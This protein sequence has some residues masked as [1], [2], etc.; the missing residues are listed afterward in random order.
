MVENQDGT[1]TLNITRGACSVD[2]EEHRK[3]LERVSVINLSASV[4]CVPDR[5][6]WGFCNLKEIRVHPENEHFIVE[7]GV[8]FSKDKKKIIRY[9]RHDGGDT[10]RI[11]DCVEEI[12]EGCFAE[13]PGLRRIDIGKGVKKI[14]YRG[15]SS[16]GSIFLE[17]VYIPPTVTELCGEIFDSGGADSGMYYPVSIVGGAAGSVIEEYCYERGIDFIVVSEDAVEDFYATSVDDLKERLKK[18]IENEKEF[19][20]DEHEKGYQAKFC[21]GVLE[22]FVPDDVIAT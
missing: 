18:Q 13:V 12:A 5:L 4:E 9:F 10:Y 1:L 14:G 19:F 11:E 7:D 3:T 22:V 16:D 6:S 2:A 8:L 15:L 21:D 17:K 20:V